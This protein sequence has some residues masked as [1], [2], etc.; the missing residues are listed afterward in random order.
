MSCADEI[1][2]PTRAVR[3]KFNKTLLATNGSGAP[4]FQEEYTSAGFDSRLELLK[5]LS[6][7]D[8]RNGSISEEDVSV[9]DNVPCGVQVKYAR[10]LQASRHSS[11]LTTLLRCPRY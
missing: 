1:F 2:G 11:I 4:A 9:L 6:W 10:G 3:E 7:A 5:R 8:P